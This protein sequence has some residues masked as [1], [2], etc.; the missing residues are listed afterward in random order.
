MTTNNNN[1][2]ADWWKHR[3]WEKHPPVSSP[4]P[5]STPT[6]AQP[7]TKLTVTF[8]SE[9]A[10]YTNSMGWYNARTG[11]AGILFV[12]LNDDGKWAG[13]K[14]GDS[15]S[16]NVLQSDLDAGNIGFFLVPDGAGRYGSS[17][18]S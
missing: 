10:G 13:V 3:G 2:W 12:D 6:P 7:T 9:E 8:N 5:S 11:E 4:A 17:T 1:I 18:L 15:R 14:A 16:L